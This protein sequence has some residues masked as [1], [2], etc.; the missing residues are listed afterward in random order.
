M[1]QKAAQES[2]ILAIRY[3]PLPGG[4]VKVTT[5][6]E[7][8]ACTVALLRAEEVERRLRGDC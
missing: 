2:P 7:S 6:W 1:I 3:D 4:W 8:G 5:L